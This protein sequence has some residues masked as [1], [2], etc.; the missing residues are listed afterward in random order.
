MSFPLA[1]NNH[2]RHVSELNRFVNVFIPSEHEVSVNS[3]RQI[4]WRALRSELEKVRRKFRSVVLFVSAKHAGSWYGRVVMTKWLEKSTQSLKM[5]ERIS[6]KTIET[7]IRH[8]KEGCEGR[9]WGETDFGKPRSDYWKFVRRT[10]FVDRRCPWMSE[11]DV[12][13]N[14]VSKPI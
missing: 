7:G 4:S 2:F 1:T 5:V 10:E 13:Y 9:V 6:I 11:L 12:C 14:E 3:V 8:S